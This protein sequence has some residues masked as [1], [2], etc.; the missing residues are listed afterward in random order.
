MA[1][2]FSPWDHGPLFG[3]RCPEGA[4]EGP[5]E[6]SQ[7]QIGEALRAPTLT[8]TPLPAG[9]G[10]WLFPS[11]PGGRCPAGADEGTGGASQ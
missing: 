2:P 5:G 1:S 9:E 3:G 8:P 6:A 10:L 4:D 11:P 7:C